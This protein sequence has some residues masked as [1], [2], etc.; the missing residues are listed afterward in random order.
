MIKYDGASLKIKRKTAVNLG[1]V[2]CTRTWS[3]G[4][5]NREIL[6]P[7][8][9]EVLPV[10]HVHVA[11]LSD[12]NVTQIVQHKRIPRDVAS[13]LRCWVATGNKIHVLY[14]IV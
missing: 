2:Q 1:A 13:P 10:V 11:P 3:L 5:H 14:L 8:S 6:A 12:V 7:E 4:G 9:P